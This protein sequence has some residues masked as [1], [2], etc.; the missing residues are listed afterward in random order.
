MW[1]IA[2][3]AEKRHA[4][5]RDAS[6]R[7]HFEP[8][9]AAVADADAI[10]VQRLGDDDVVGPR[11]AEAAVLG[12]PGDAGKAAALFVDGAADFDRAVAAR[13]RRG[14]CLRPQRAP[15]DSGLHVA[16]S[17]AVNP[18]VD[19]VAAERIARPAIA[20]RH[21]V[22]VA[23][24]V[25]DRVRRAPAP[26]ADDVDARVAAGVLGTALGGEV[27]DL[28]GA[29]LQAIANQARAVVVGLAGRVDRRNA[30]QI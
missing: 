1:S 27:L 20:G 26:R 3:D 16:R 7:Q 5:M 19:D 22:E 11:G 4:A 24:Q 14:G 30:D 2:L 21:D 28:E 10:D 17:A 8:V 25:H 15:R 29:A 6:A 23:V 9:H 13:R 18:P 12:E